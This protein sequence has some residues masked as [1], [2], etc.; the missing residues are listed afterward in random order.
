MPVFLRSA[1]SRTDNLQQAEQME[2]QLPWAMEMLQTT[3]NKH[4]KIMNGL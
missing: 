3:F 4:Q 2:T 1:K